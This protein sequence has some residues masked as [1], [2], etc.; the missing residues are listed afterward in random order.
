MVKS[1]L[2]KQC[3]VKKYL[4]YVLWRRPNKSIFIIYAKHVFPQQCLY[5][6]NDHHGSVMSGGMVNKP[7]LFTVPCENASIAHSGVQLYIRLAVHQN[8]GEQPISCCFALHNC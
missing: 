2:M 8:K 6:A 4:K 7:I 5:L 3:K 1:V